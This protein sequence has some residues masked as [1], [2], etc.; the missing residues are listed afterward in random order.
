[1]LKKSITVTQPYLPPLE[2]FI[3][4]LKEIWKNKWLTNNGPLHQ[5]LE[6]KLADYLG[7]KYISLFSNGTKNHTV[8][9]PYYSP[10]RKL[11]RSP[12]LQSLL[13]SLHKSR[14]ATIIVNRNGDQTFIYYP[15]SP[16]K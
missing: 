10:S 8:I 16:N 3:P 15:I 13:N 12:Y 14:N 11:K 1:M 9:F 5:E 6:K 2:E 7:V 4:Y